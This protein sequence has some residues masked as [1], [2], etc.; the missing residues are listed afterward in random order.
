RTRDMSRYGVRFGRK[1]AGVYCGRDSVT[2]ASMMSGIITTQIAFYICPPPSVRF[3]WQAERSIRATYRRG[4]SL[5]AGL[6][7]GAKRGAAVQRLT[8]L[9]SSW[10]SGRGGGLLLPCPVMGRARTRLPGEGR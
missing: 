5:A 7:P 9:V 3:D 8:E 1:V 6:L 4:P 10:G 2:S